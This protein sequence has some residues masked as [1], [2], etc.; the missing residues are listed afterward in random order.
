MFL[1]LQFKIAQLTISLFLLYVRMYCISAIVP[2]FRDLLLAF[3]GFVFRSLSFLDVSMFFL[4][5]GL[6]RQGGARWGKKGRK[7]EEAEEDEEDE[8]EEEEEEDENEDEED[9]EED[10]DEEEEDEEDEEEDEEDEEE[11]EEEEEDDESWTTRKMKLAN[12]WSSRRMIYL[13]RAC[14][15]ASSMEI[16]SSSRG[17]SSSSTVQTAA[18]FNGEFVVFLITK[19]IGRTAFSA[20]LN[21]PPSKSL[22]SSPHSCSKSKMSMLSR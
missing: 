13:L 15:N 11:E 17:V 18:S 8:D 4:L 14:S 7:E 21:P 5:R 3:A 10:E 22:M 16:R 6:G 19:T 1:F 9:E 2:F 12:L 20:I